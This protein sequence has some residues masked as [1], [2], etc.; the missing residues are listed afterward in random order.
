M[1]YQI[2]FNHH[3]RKE[4]GYDM[5]NVHKFSKKVGKDDEDT[6]LEQVISL[7]QKQ[8]ARRDILVT[9]VEVFEF[10]KKK[11]KFKE[12][13]GG[14]IIKD[15]KFMMD[16]I[17][18]VP[19]VSESGDEGGPPPPWAGGLQPHEIAARQAM[20]PQFQNAP[21]QQLAL[22]LNMRPQFNES[23]IPTAMHPQRFEVFD[24]DPM[25]QAKL[26]NKY[27]LTPGKKYGIY[28]EWGE[29]IPP[30]NVTKYLIK[31]DRGMEITI[32]AEY[33]VAA[34]KG[35]IGGSF[36]ADPVERQINRGLS[37]QG[38]YLED[39]GIPVQQHSQPMLM[40]DGE[41]IPADLLK[42]PDITHLRG[43]I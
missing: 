8:F 41:D 43:R 9:D 13:K 34:G 4:S 37:F 17:H 16:Q 23:G 14:F 36:D 40:G 22:P 5:E 12:V 21:P 11:V 2:L 25:Q 1:G 33:F 38:Q 26:G 19:V 42:M 29:G 7:I 15:K 28:R 39:R 24:P 35:L 10:V 27:K 3:K 6:P 18:D 20:M 30:M 31:D 32:S